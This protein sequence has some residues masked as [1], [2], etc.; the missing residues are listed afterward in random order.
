M[1]F[2]CSSKEMPLSGRLVMIREKVRERLELKP[3][4][5]KHINQFNGLLRYVFQVTN[6]ELQKSGYEDGEL[7]RSKRPMLKQADAFGWFDQDKLVSQICIYPYEVNIHGRIFK[8][9]GLTGVGTYP[10]YSG[11]GLMNDLIRTGLQ[12][13]RKHHQWISYLYPYSIPYYRDKGWEIMSDHMTFK[14]KDSQL[15]HKVEVPGFVERV[16]VGHS[17]VLQTYDRFARQTH[18]ALI[19]NS[20]AWEEYWRWENEEERSAAVYYEDP[21]E[22]SGYLIYWIEDDVFHI[23]EMVYLNQEARRGLW[24]FIHAHYSMIDEVRGHIYKNEPLAFYLDDSQIEETIEPYMM[25]RIVDV[26]EF[27]R[28][29]PFVDFY[30]PFHFVVSDPLA[31]WN[32][33]VFGISGRKD[34]ENI[35]TDK[36][37]GGAVELD[38]RTL[39]ATLMNYR[40]ASFFA[41]MERLKTDI[42]TL[43]LLESMITSQQPYFSDYF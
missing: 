15:P 40:L 39:T 22:P 5:L 30:E 11:L 16:G 37:V 19:R 2:S 14:V 21:H 41:E 20:L 23:K 3:V 25:A 18:G 29:Y 10:E 33:G 34:G 26:K 28:R 38:I 4:T 17:D 13:M 27:L 8:M 32:N 36:P 1:G 43:K 9:G 35:V 42:E 31:G 6:E 24:N 7:V 12:K